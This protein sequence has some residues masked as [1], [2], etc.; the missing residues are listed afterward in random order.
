[1]HFT[2]L[3]TCFQSLSLSQHLSYYLPAF[4]HIW[5]H[6][7]LQHWNMFFIKS[8]MYAELFLYISSLF[9]SD[10]KWCFRPS[11]TL[12]HCLTAPAMA[13]M[14]CP[15]TVVTLHSEHFR[16]IPILYSFQSY[17][18]FL[19]SRN[20]DVASDN[21][22]CRIQI[23]LTESYPKKYKPVWSESHP[24]KLCIYLPVSQGHHPDSVKAKYVSI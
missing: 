7:F 1:M 22:Q 17:N 15:T 19:V 5:K 9:I 24:N 2:L 18:K 23:D 21:I 10:H 13:S 8:N 11:V 3:I 6:N 4:Q 12:E 14:T 20:R 16:N